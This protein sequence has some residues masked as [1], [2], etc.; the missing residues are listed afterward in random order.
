M[1]LVALCDDNPNHRKGSLFRV[2]I[3][4]MELKPHGSRKILRYTVGHYCEECM[5]SKEFH[6]KAAL[7]RP[8]KGKGRKGKHG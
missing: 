1:S 2:S 8:G 6:V 4:A 5:Q 7:L 3:E